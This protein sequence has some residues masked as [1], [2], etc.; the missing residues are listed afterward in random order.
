MFEC[1]NLV[2]IDLYLLFY[3]FNSDTLHYLKMTYLKVKTD[4]YLTF[5]VCSALS[6]Q[7]SSNIS[8]NPPSIPAL[9]YRCL[10]LYC[11]KFADV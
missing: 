6:V 2:A 1:S 9:V 3:L 8:S 11:F 10:S 7:V 4:F 5:K